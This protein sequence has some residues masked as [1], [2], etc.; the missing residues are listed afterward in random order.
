MVIGGLVFLLGISDLWLES[1]FD[2]ICLL[3]SSGVALT[4]LPRFGR[5]GASLLAARDRWSALILFLLLGFVEDC[6]V[7]D[8][9]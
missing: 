6:A 8:T 3:I 7:R 2:K 4:L 1:I 5:A 9:S